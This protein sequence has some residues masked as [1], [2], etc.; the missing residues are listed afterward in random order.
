MSGAGSNY[1][2]SD[3]RYLQQT[4]TAT[5]FP[6]GVDALPGM[7]YPD[8]PGGD[9]ANAPRNPRTV[10]TN[11]YPVTGPALPTNLGMLPY[12]SLTQVEDNPQTQPEE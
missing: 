12:G 5:K 1:A 3:G 11:D 6:N 4:N 9:D 10:L 7:Q 8:F 2:V